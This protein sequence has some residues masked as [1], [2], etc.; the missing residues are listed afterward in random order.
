MWIY[1]HVHISRK[2][3]CSA[4]QIHRGKCVLFCHICTQNTDSG[5]PRQT[6]AAGQTD[7]RGEGLDSKPLNLRGETQGPQGTTRELGS[8]KQP[9]PQHLGTLHCFSQLE[10]N[11]PVCSF[12]SSGRALKVGIHLHRQASHRHWELDVLLLT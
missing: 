9:S 3:V 4:H 5:T 6:S 7:V 12:L 2:R 10:M 11:H 8:G 1:T